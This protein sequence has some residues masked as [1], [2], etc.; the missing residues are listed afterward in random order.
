M[1]PTPPQSVSTVATYPVARCRLG[2]HDFILDI[3][4]CPDATIDGI[5]ELLP[6]PKGIPLVLCN[7]NGDGLFQI[8]IRQANSIQSS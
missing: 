5:H 1:T 7:E 2:L 6:N 8:T 3:N 4:Y